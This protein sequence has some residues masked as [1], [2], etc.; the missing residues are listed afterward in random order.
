MRL[1]PAN[2]VAEIGWVT[3]SPRLQRTTAATEAVFLL[4]RHVFGL[5]TRHHLFAANPQHRPAPAAGRGSQRGCRAG[6]RRVEWKCDDRNAPSRAAAA[7]LGFAYEGT[8]RQAVV[9]K[10]RSRDT[11]WHAVVDGEWPRLRRG[12]EA[13]LSP[14]N[15]DEGGLS[16]GR[17]SH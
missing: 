16:H 4:L 12:F 9:Y 17:Y 14:D 2:G 10:G 6:Y 13:W 5:G 8:F 3:L 15:F 1:D 7:R 11:A